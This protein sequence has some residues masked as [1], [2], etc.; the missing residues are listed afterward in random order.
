VTVEDVTAPDITCP[1]DQNEDFDANCE[2]ILPDYTALATVSDSCDTNPTV[3][4]SPIPGTT[5][6]G[7]TQITLSAEDAYGNMNTCVFDVIPEDN[8]AP[9]ITCPA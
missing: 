3:T 4:Q 1:A 9:T 5:I 7:T 2:F 6:T 8:T